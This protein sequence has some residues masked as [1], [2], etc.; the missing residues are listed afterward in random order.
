MKILFIT[1]WFQPEPFL[2]GLGFAKELV[3]L[4]HSVQVL[5]GFPNYPGGKIYDGY[6]IKFIQREVLEGIPII[7]VPLYPSHDRFT[8]K[9][10]LN[11]LSFAFSA[12]A[13]GTWAINKAD[14]AYVYHP[15]A[16]TC[17]P[18]WLIKLLRGIPFIYNIQDLWPDALISPMF[19]N[20]AGIW[21]MDKFCR[22]SYKLSSKIVAQSPG[23]KTK[24]M[25]RGVDE[26]KIEVIYNWCDDTQIHTEEYNPALAKE[27]GMDQRFN[28]LF[29]GGMGE[30][31]ALLSV[32]QA[33]DLLKTCAPQIQFVFIGDGIRLQ[34]LKDKTNELNLKNVKFLP[35]RPP[36]EIGGI[37]AL[38]QV[39]LV[40]L[41]DS[42]LHLITIPS[43][44]QA[45]LAVGKPILIAV[46][47]DAADLVM[48]SGAGIKCEPEN[49]QEIAETA[50][51]FLNMTQEDLSEMGR[52]GRDYYFRELSLE[53]G[54][55]KYEKIFLDIV[56]K[57]K[58]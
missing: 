28:I 58:H 40:H 57:S 4:G 21:I 33:A 52:K 8:S 19:K 43:K 41:K 48:Q 2:N 42:V 35:R 7:R 3:K 46:R 22:L 24:L 38:A 50:K 17:F 29:A 34:L 13:I 16:T 39:M 12:A 54:V 44:I 14:V 27:L 45:Y 25:E 1:Q 10:I 56:N 6:K 51:R 37:M 49:P 15:P 30:G 18:A 32:I 36:S 5:T 53:V 9:R 23:F 31:Q 20:K 26:E 55:K 47:G 11:Y